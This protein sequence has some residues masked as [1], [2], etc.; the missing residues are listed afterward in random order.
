MPIR[1]NLLAEAQAAEE[2]RRKDPV[3]RA[4]ML[5]IFLT[6]GVLGWAGLIQF[7]AIVINSELS[8][9]TAQMNQCTNE[10]AHIVDM[11]KKTGD[12][13]QKLTALTALST[14]RFLNGSLLNALQHTTVEDVQ[15]TRLKIEQIFH[16]TEETKARTNDNV[17]VPGKPAKITEKTMLVL[18]GTDSSQNPG[19]QVLRMKDT[20]GQFPYFKASL[21]RANAVAWKSS[22]S[23]QISPETGRSV[24]T[25]TLE[26][27]YPDKTR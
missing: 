20:I 14:N 11:Q 15:L 21:D 19:D 25:F 2:L 27:R 23:P 9:V 24:V 4:I 1:L 16:Y 10:Y 26:C 7:K 8:K 22:S 17:V 12:M 5:G 6:V 18:D 13:N 3:K